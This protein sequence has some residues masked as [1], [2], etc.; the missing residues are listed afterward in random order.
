MPPSSRRMIRCD[1]GRRGFLLI[2]SGCADN[3]KEYGPFHNVY[4]FMLAMYIIAVAHICM[5]AVK[6]R[7]IVSYKT[8]ILYSFFLF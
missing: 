6:R 3:R 5:L 7:N 1:D 4:Y 2:S 8:T